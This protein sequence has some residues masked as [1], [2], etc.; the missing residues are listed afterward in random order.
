[1]RRLLVIVLLAS[2]WFVSACSGGNATGT[3][4]TNPNA[5]SDKGSATEKKDPKDIKP[6]SLR[7]AIWDEN[8]KSAMDAIVKKFNEKYPQIEVQVELIAP[9]TQYLL[10]LETSATG[11]SA[12]DVFWMNAQYFYKYARNGILEPLSDL[13][14]RDQFDTKLIYP[15]LMQ[16]F[17]DKGQVF[18]IPKDYDSMGLWYNKAMFDE[19][20]IP[21]PDDTWDW[22]KLVEVSKKLTNP[23]KG[24]WGFAAQA[25]DRYS[26]YNTI[27]QNG[28]KIIKADG[29][30]GYDSPE[31]IE[32]VKY[33]TDFIHVHKVSPT[34][35]QMTDT[36]ALNMFKT[37]K[38]AM[39]I[40]GSWK[41][42]ELAEDAYTSKNADVAVLPKGKQR[43]TSGNSLAYAMYSGSKNKEQAWE[44]M[45]FLG[46]K[47]AAEIQAVHR[48]VIPSHIG[49]ESAW[50]QSMPQFKLQVFADMAKYIEIVPTS[51]ETAKW[52]AV[53]TKQFQRAWAGEISVEEAAK[54][55]AQEMNTIL[56]EEK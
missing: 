55:V 37:G 3:A 53:A 11:R 23:S 27:P 19:A 46:S 20:K 30:S 13:I 47:E 41:A 9:L 32:A 35:E 6:A 10:K 43:A 7:F 29:T 39:V 38:V 42:S 17:T 52:K 51:V 2:I 21:Y 24:V 14:K 25:G 44:F 28:G 1:V 34:L 31:A 12:P 15:N 4:G 26:F 48:A 8:Q 49:S 5:A 16:M 54:L 56:K 40:D 18:A 22:N 33:W 45:K 50:I 36:T